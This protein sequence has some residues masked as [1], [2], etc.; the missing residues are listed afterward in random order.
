MFGSNWKLAQRIPVTLRGAYW[1]VPGNGYLCV[2]SHG[3]MASNTTGTTCA[4]TWYAVEHGVVDVTVAGAAPGSRVPPARLIVG[5]APNDAHRVVVR[6]RGAVET[7]QVVKDMFVL[8]DSI[9]APPD[10][11]VPR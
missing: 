5:V 2:I 6:T 11:I 9:V 8:R 1:L 3:S 7:A 4:P 10:S